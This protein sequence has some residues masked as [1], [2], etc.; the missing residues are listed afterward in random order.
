MHI[1]TLALEHDAPVVSF[2][3][4]FDRFDGVRWRLPAAAG[5]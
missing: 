3:R 1:A 4:D 2:D 5:S